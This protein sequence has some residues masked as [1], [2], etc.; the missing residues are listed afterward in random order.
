MYKKQLGLQKIACYLAILSSAIWFIYSMGMITDI[1]DALYYTMLN[2]NDLSDTLVDG[3]ILYYDMQDFNKAFMYVGIVLIL[4]ACLLFLTNTHSRRRYYIGNYAATAV[5][6]V[7]SLVTVV[8]SHLEISA[9]K[10][11]YLTTVDFEA[12]KT[13]SETLSTIKYTES[14]FLLDLHWAVAGISLLAVGILVA[15]MIWKISL[16][17]GEEQLIEAGKE[18]VRL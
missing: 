15:N 11:Q 7:T 2:P 10:Q 14:T 17:R 5:Y 3:S 8:W 18:A 13:W 9:F 12:L 4:L 6:C 16:M 1:F